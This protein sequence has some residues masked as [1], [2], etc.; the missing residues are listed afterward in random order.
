MAENHP[1]LA[2]EAMTNWMCWALRKSRA[3]VL[4][5]ISNLTEP[6]PLPNDVPQEL[7]RVF[8]F[9]DIMI[10]LACGAVSR[11]RLELNPNHI[12]PSPAES[13]SEAEIN[14]MEFVRTRC[15][16][17][18][19]TWTKGLRSHVPKLMIRDRRQIGNIMKDLLPELFSEKELT[20][21]RSQ[22]QDAQR[23]AVLVAVL[24]VHGFL[25]RD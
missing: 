17:K 20:D 7:A 24:Q 6:T 2:V 10:G 15:A 14:E 16:D 11:I 9:V 25:R 5:D 19:Y 1:D 18:V 21:L 8:C 13:V 23:A 4:T 22:L 3:S 12:K